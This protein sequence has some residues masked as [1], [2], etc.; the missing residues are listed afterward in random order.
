VQAEVLKQQE[1]AQRAKVRD[2]RREEWRRENQAEQYMADDDDPFAT[3]ASTLDDSL[4]WGGA[5]PDDDIDDGD[6]AAQG[7]GKAV[8]GG[9][10]KIVEPSLLTLLAVGS[11]MERGRLSHEA[12]VDRQRDL[13]DK[14]TS[15]E[16]AEEEEEEEEFDP[17]AVAQAQEREREKR[18]RLVAEGRLRPA[19][20]WG[21]ATARAK[22]AVAAPQSDD[23]PP[24]EQKQKR[25]KS[26][27]ISTAEGVDQARRSAEAKRLVYAYPKSVARRE[28][29]AQ[30]Q[31]EFA[32]KM[33]TARKRAQRRVN[34]VRGG[35]KRQ[36]KRPE[37]SEASRWRAAAVRREQARERQRAGSVLNQAV[38]AEKTALAAAAGQTLQQYD[39]MTGLEGLLR[40]Q[41][42]A[43]P[44]QEVERLLRLVGIPPP[45]LGQGGKGTRQQ[46]L[47]DVICNGCVAGFHPS[48][49]VPFAA[50]A[51]WSTIETTYNTEHARLVHQAR[52]R[53]K[54]VP[55]ARSGVAARAAERALLGTSSAPH[56]S[57]SP[58]KQCYRCL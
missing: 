19:M 7:L 48:R 20:D 6:E 26:V 32:E 37:A 41:V 36:E 4:Y 58:H 12:W 16:E 55:K 25:K 2:R 44:L 38:G 52:T 54:R 51:L 21:S 24:R 57:V 49:G 30:E 15:S 10:V 5:G 18:L 34:D 13:A 46:L 53:R 56:G 50:S 45:E 11:T 42:M 47:L 31:K 28:R 35:V 22:S 17:V 43:A 23:T 3:T 27:T 33:E 29:E 8:G 9:F 1:R 39:K 14:E 40:D